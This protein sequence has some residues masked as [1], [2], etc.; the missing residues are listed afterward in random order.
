M[1]STRKIIDVHMYLVQ[2]KKGTKPYAQVICQA[3]IIIDCVVLAAAA[4]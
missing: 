1:D 2:Q 3:I 4:V